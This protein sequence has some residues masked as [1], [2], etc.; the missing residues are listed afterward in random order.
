MWSYELLSSLPAPG[1]S[2]ANPTPKITQLEK[3]ARPQTSNIYPKP[4][5]PDELDIVRKKDKF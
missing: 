1:D 3:K 5:L 4:H 2:G